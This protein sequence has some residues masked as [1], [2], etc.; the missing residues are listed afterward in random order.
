LSVQVTKY[1]QD[2]TRQPP[3]YK[4]VVGTSWTSFEIYWV[5]HIPGTLDRRS[6]VV[7]KH[8]TGEEVARFLT[9]EDAVDDF[10]VRDAEMRLGG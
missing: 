10:K 6:W 5:Q 1:D 2:F 4:V 9:A 8:R 3:A 7:F